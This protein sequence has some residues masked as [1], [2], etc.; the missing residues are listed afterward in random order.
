MQGSADGL[1]EP[2]LEAH[3]PEE[4]YRARTPVQDHWEVTM[5]VL[6]ATRPNQKITKG[7]SLTH[8]EPVML[9]TPPDIEQLQV[10]ATTLKLQDVTV[11]AKPNLS[12]GKSRELKELLTEYGDIFAIKSDDYGWT[13]KV[14]HHIDKGEA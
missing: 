10:Q 8:Y 12:D 4:L 13:D 3:T 9:M 6:N 1:V 11:A 2:S 5:R 14:Y 7:S